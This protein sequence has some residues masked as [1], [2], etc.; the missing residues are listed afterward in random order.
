M[1]AM[2]AAGIYSQSYSFPSNADVAMMVQEVISTVRCN[3]LSSSI[4]VFTITFLSCVL[5]RLIN[6]ISFSL[7][8]AIKHAPYLVI[9]FICDYNYLLCNPLHFGLL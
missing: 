1:M 6:K 7:I 8:L 3:T 9:V 4:V 5:C 2:E